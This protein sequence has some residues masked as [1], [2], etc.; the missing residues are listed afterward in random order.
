M[1]KQSLL[2]LEAKN[3]GIVKTCLICRHLNLF[4]KRE[5]GG[6]ITTQWEYPC[7]RFPVTA[8]KEIDDCC[9]EFKA[10]EGV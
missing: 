4:K 1:K 9:A 10:K 5:K 3:D 6:V 2:N 8:W 7:N